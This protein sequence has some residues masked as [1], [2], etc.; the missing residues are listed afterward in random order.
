M[1]RSSF[2]RP[3]YHWLLVA[4]LLGVLALENL[5]GD[6]TASSAPAADADLAS[7][8]LMYE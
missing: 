8:P 1:S 5:P 4:L 3:R 6:A 7:L 2:R